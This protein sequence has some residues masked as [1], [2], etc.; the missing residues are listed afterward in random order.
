LTH[1][2]HV[3]DAIALLP[4]SAVLVVVQQ[5][6]PT[7]AP[8][9]LFLLRHPFDRSLPITG[10]TFCHRSLAAFLRI[11]H[12]AEENAPFSPSFSEEKALG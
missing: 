10:Q 5:F 7:I 12:Y 3:N 8:A 11:S 4:S 2:H 9:S 6:P 1:H